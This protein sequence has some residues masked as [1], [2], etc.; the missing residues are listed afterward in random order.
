MVADRR[1]DARSFA[2]EQGVTVIGSVDVL[3]AAIDVGK[4]DEPTLMN[5]YQPDQRHWILCSISNDFGILATPLT[6]V[7]VFWGEL[8]SNQVVCRNPNAEPL[9]LPGFTVVETSA[10]NA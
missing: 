1:W 8:I 4:I 9:H 10:L 6:V 7:S 3:L 2:K 5:G